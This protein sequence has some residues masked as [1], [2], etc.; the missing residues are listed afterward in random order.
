MT[1]DRSDLLVEG[2]WEHREISA[3]GLRFHAATAGDGPLVLFLH[4]FP[5]NWWA[6]RNQ[7]VSFADA[8]FRV[9]ALDLRGYGATDHTPRGYDMPSLAADTAAVIRSLGSAEALVVGHAWGGAIGWSLAAA[10]PKLVRRLVVVSSPHPRRLRKAFLTDPAQFA[11][12][13]YS[14]SFQAPWAPER[15]LVRE[16]ARR[17]DTLLHRWA[18]PGWPDDETS[19]FYRQSMQVGNT[20]YCAMEYYRWAIRSVPRPDG[21]RYAATMRTPIGVPVLQLHGAADT[22][23]LPRSAQGSG[24]YVVA[25]YRWRLLDGVGH[26]P[27][28][29]APDRFDAEVLGWLADPE[30]DR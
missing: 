30:P 26:F 5:E 27:H 4:G 6:W 29:E 12:A 25:P 2:P 28:E 13:R 23:V 16:D 14:L 10:Q 1:P 20:A 7:L 21:M 24:E 11:A 19:G 15:M 18:A 17:V 8:G 3:N 9:V 22:C